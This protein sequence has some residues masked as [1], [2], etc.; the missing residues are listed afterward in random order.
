M[1]FRMYMVETSSFSRSLR[2]WTVSVELDLSVTCTEFVV[3]SSGGSYYMGGYG[4][5]TNEYFCCRV[6]FPLPSF[7]RSDHAHLLAVWKFTFSKASVNVWCLAAS[8]P[9][10]SPS[11]ISLSLVSRQF[12]YS[13]SVIKF[14]ISIVYSQCFFPPKITIFLFLPSGLHRNL[15]YPPRKCTITRPQ[16]KRTDFYI[17]PIGNGNFGQIFLPSDNCTPPPKFHLHLQFQ[18]FHFFMHKKKL[19]VNSKCRK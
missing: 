15:R 2:K 11:A 8:R 4:V 18:L 10:R 7:H 6:G 9:W 5:W 16:W 12:W 13:S 3:W 1:E 17:K 14:T 19:R